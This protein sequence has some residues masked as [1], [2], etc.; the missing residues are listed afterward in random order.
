MT[1]VVGSTGMVG[2]E[3]CRLL[4]ASGKGVTALVRASA[5]PAKVE[6]LKRAGATIAT[7]DLRDRGSLAAACRGVTSVI[8]S[9]S[10]IPFGYVPGDNT[11]DR[12]DRDGGL[13]LIDAAREAGVQQFVYVSVPQSPIAF[14]LY[15]AKRAVENRLRESGLVHTILRPTYF[16]EVWLSPAV[17]FDY[18]NRKAAIFGDGENAI[19]WISFRDVAQFA[20]ASLNHAA[21]RNATLD[22]GGPEA[23]TPHQA[24]VLF[25]QAGGRPFEVTHVPISALQEQ[26]GA[27]QD[28]MQKTFAALMLGY[29]ATTPIDMTATLKTFP[30]TLGTV[31]EYARNVTFT[32]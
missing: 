12:T 11:P 30:L 19:S 14:P 31:G 32:S 27:A 17:G 26:L 5:D 9:A 16:T 24:I 21:S 15:D 6:T 29:A 8:S 3:V 23:I 20:T 10:A 22:L 4:A 28:P 18:A 7:G 25:E 1:L 13:S 2:A